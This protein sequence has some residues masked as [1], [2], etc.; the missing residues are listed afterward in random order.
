LIAAEISAKY[1]NKMALLEIERKREDA[2]LRARADDEHAMAE[3]KFAA[4]KSQLKLESEQRIT[5]LKRELKYTI[6]NARKLK[7][8]KEENLTLPLAFVEGSKLACEVGFH[9]V[10]LLQD[11]EDTPEG[12]KLT[13]EIDAEQKSKYDAKHQV[14]TTWQN[15]FEEK[16]LATLKHLVWK[17]TRDGNEMM[18][19][20][21]P[22]L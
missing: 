19:S 2:E 10:D 7:E 13:V 3:Q 1:K 16:D 5:N 18:D 21:T 22:S 20:P 12:L 17:N 11:S 6:E 4:T 8:E 14:V 9:L 15:A